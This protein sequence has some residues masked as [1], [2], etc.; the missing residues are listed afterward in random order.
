MALVNDV[1][2][3]VPNEPSWAMNLFWV[4]AGFLPILGHILHFLKI[5]GIF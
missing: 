4:F 2:N 1:E 5:E 3:F